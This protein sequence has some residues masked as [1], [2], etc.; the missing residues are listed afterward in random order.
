MGTGSYP[1]N[2]AFTRRYNSLQ[3]QVDGPLGL[4]W[5]HSFD[6]SCKISS[7]II[8][9]LADDSVIAGVPAIVNLFIAT[10]LLTDLSRPNDKYLTVILSSQ[11][12]ADQ[13]KSNIASVNTG[14]L[15]EIFVKLP[16]A[17]FVAESCNNDSSFVINLDGSYTYQNVDKVTYEF[18]S[19]G[20]L[21]TVSFPYGVTLT[22]SYTSGHLTSITNNMGRTLSLSYLGNR[23]QTVSDGNGRSVD[24]TL[25]VDS[26]LSQ[27][28]DAM[29][30]IYTYE[31]DLPGQ[32]TKLYFPENPSTTL[33]TNTY[34]SL[35][36]VKEQRDFANN[37]TSFY[38]S[39]HRN[40]WVGPIGNNGITY[41][42]SGG[43]AVRIINAL[44]FEISKKYDGR[45]RLTQVLE[46]EGN[47][48]NFEYDANNNVTQV[49][50]KAKPGSGLSDLTNIL[51][52]DPNW[53][54]LSTFTDTAGKTTE[55]TY[56]AVTGACTTITRPNVGGLTPQQH[57]T[58]NSRGQISSI[59]DEA[60][61]VT[62]LTYDATTEKLLSIVKDPGV[63]PHLNIT[64]SFT[65]DA[66]G[67]L[68]TSTDPL[69]GVTYFERNDLRR[70][71]QVTSP[72]P[73]SFVS[74][75]S[76]DD[77]GNL[78]KFERQTDFLGNPWLTTQSSYRANLT[79]ETITDEK[80]GVA[81]LVSDAD[82]RFQSLTD[83]VNRT[84]SQ[85]YDSLGQQTTITA[86]DTNIFETRTY[87]PNGKLATVK[88]AVNN[89]TTFEYDG[90]DRFVKRTYQ[91][92]S[93]EE[94]TLDA[95]SNVTTVRTRSGAHITMQYDELGRL[96]NKSADSQPPV[97]YSYDLASKLKE[98]STPVSGGGITAGSYL[99][100]YDSCGRF[101]QEQA[102]DGKTAT[103]QLDLMGRLIK[104]TYPD[105]YFVER[106]YDELGR[107]ANI[108]LNGSVSNA[109][110]F[111]YNALS[112]RKKLTF[113]N[114]VTTDYVYNSDS[115]LKSFK[116][117]FNSSSGYVS[118]D[119][120]N[121]ALNRT[122]SIRTN[123]VRYRWS[124]NS[125]GTVSYGAATSTNECTTVGGDT[126]SY[127][128]SGCLVGDGTWTYTYN[129]EN[130][131]L[132]A[133][134]TGI[135]VDYEYDP[136]QRQA[137]KR[138]GSNSTLYFYSG[139]QRL[140]EY[141]L[142]SGTLI[143]RFVYGS[144]SDEVLL[145][146]DASGVVTFYSSDPQLSVN[147]ITDAGGSV[148]SRSRYS[149]YG[150]TWSDFNLSHGYTGQRYDAETELYYYKHRIYSP[151]LGRF[152]Q[153]DPIGY[154]DGYNLYCYAGNSPINRCDYFGLTWQ[155]NLAFLLDFL[156]GSGED[157]RNYGEGDVQTQEVKNSPLGW[158]IQLCAYGVGRGS[159]DFDTAVT[160]PWNTNLA[161]LTTVAPGMGA[162]AAATAS[163][164][165]K[166]LE[167][168][169]PFEADSSSPG[170]KELIQK[171]FSTD[172]G[173]WG[174]TAAQLGGIEMDP[175]KNGPLPQNNEYI[176]LWRTSDST[177]HVQIQNWAT[178]DSFFAHA[179]EWVSPGLLTALD[180]AG[181]GD[182]AQ[183][184]AKLREQADNED[185]L[186]RPIQQIFDFEVHAPLF[187]GW[188]T[189]G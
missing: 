185:N 163:V 75:Y 175:G 82:G 65:Y 88:D 53:N 166:A 66:A 14:H 63:F 59:T 26:N 47:S 5:S 50:F 118:F 60:G 11:W 161:F 109:V 80:L 69:G 107:L 171:A 56:D 48:V 98:V 36:R 188:C 7:G 154:R 64:V 16:D 18:N 111:E 156:T 187:L 46:P 136:L 148:L 132:S 58:Y 79:T 45:N 78:N 44:G 139:W 97:T 104:T 91:D 183:G 94:F 22:Y 39:G 134:K 2:L 35:G 180:I 93:Y 143:R 77:N 67:N 33:L 164:A 140:A 100:D 101:I 41:F 43:R 19:D 29:G 179:Q 87:T 120:N 12:W 9:A 126:I 89:V 178:A 165:G 34:D 10:D 21:E 128:S 30:N 86:P 90:F 116:H 169:S 157:V 13:L 3:R 184:L 127:N 76:Y 137:V 170:P 68:V 51:T 144:A 133:N 96:V 113:Q 125:V 92:G 138:V 151:R 124:P 24:Y 186:W 70:I 130:K 84:I 40:E 38:L 141:D 146:I 62:T 123:D 150:E 152:L 155:T 117:T 42:N 95:R 73:F 112:Q 57:A 52:W 55:W 25:D 6:A 182:I 74:K 115:S 176:K 110:H 122:K 49:L 103:H 61:L 81:Q 106:E 135:S 142:T 172:P 168:L 158:Y 15:T 160:V 102:A 121:D 119:V 105:G 174:N 32:M 181:F 4:G 23:L 189:M 37:L 114:G 54:R 167:S 28:T 147:A 149:P 108:K 83:Q 153:P 85:N 177:V 31:Y 173:M 159:K 99:L 72:A 71:T 1:Y 145:S 131:L 8:P 17:T 20:Q 129:T 27:F 162:L